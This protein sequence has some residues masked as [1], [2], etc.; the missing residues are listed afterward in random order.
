MADHDS[1]AGFTLIE[2][3]VAFAIFVVAMASLYEAAS[4]A[5]RLESRAQRQAEAL[6][7]ARAELE[8]L[9]RQPL[10]AG[11]QTGTFPN[12]SVWTLDVAPIAVTRA[13]SESTVAPAWLTLSA[14]D[15]QGREL[16]TLRTIAL[17][18]QARR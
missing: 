6:A 18:E 7:Y 4:V 14:S 8:S 12:G 15:T 11:R 17:I 13:V 2:A 9:S 10:G 16:V 5:F 3:L 1:E